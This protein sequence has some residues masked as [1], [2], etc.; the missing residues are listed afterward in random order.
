MN[1]SVKKSSVNQKDITNK[2]RQP[3]IIAVTSG[4][5]GVGKTT[6]TVNLGSSIHQFNQRVIIS[7]LI[8]ENEGCSFSPRCPDP[9]KECK[10]QELDMELIE[11]SKGHW[12]DQ[13]CIN[14]G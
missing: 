5:G 11:V 9:S 10:N 12:A 14:C 1:Q 2:N 3:Q 13:C 6:T 8:N 4:K 7:S